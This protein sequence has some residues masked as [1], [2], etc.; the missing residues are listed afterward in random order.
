MVFRRREMGVANATI[1]NC[2][3]TTS[4][5]RNSYL[6]T[7][8]ALAMLIAAFILFGLSSISGVYQTHVTKVV[9][10]Y[11]QSASYDYTYDGSNDTISSATTS[12]STFAVDDE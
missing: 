7:G 12:T 4:A 5:A 8:R 1:G 9:M 11:Y 3:S 2:S 6:V 10:N